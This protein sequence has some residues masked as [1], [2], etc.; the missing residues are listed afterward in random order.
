M[1]NAVFC[2]RGSSPPSGNP[3]ISQFPRDLRRQKHRP[4][5]FLCAGAAKLPSSGDKPGAGPVSPNQ[6]STGGALHVIPAWRLGSLLVPG[7]PGFWWR[8]ESVGK[9][10]PRFARSAASG[11]GV[12]A[13]PAPVPSSSQGSLAP[14]QLFAWLL[15][16]AAPWKS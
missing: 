2:K 6:V 13:L 15:G 14:S 4:G 7:I 1:E 5:V 9:F 16:L 11:A 8:R 12:C 10:C 3:R